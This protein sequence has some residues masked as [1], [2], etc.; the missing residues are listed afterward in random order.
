[1]AVRVIVRIFK[2]TIDCGVPFDQGVERIY[3][4]MYTWV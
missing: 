4:D 1:M 2:E 3:T